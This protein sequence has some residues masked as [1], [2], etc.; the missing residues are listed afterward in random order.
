MF[1]LEPFKLL[2]KTFS[3]IIFIASS[4]FLATN[5]SYSFENILFKEFLIIDE[6][7]TIRIEGFL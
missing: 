6:S 1:S 3:V 7:S 4:P 2:D 5:I